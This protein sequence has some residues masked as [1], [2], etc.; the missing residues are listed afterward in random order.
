MGKC[1]PS[2]I[3]I[4]DS[5]DEDVHWSPF[6]TGRPGATPHPGNNY[7]DP[8]PNTF[9]TDESDGSTENWAESP[10]PR[11]LGIEYSTIIITPPRWH[12]PPNSPSY[13]EVTQNISQGIQMYSPASPFNTVEH[14][15]P[16]NLSTRHRFVSEAYSFETSERTE[17]E[18]LREHV[19]ALEYSNRVRDGIHLATVRELEGL[20]AYYA[21]R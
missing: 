12:I 6:R 16:L 2:I 8:E 9:S 3:L 18:R 19:Q 14:E 1:D 10:E 11:D 13:L 20:L 17:I 15:T 5:E 21:N 7:G 4:S